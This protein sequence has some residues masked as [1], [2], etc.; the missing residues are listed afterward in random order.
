[1]TPSRP[2][3]ALTSRKATCPGA[4]WVPAVQ[5]AHGIVSHGS[6]TGGAA[7]DPGV[8][9]GLLHPTNRARQRSERAFTI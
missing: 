2:Q 7:R 6:I 1:M 8:G 5:T 9:T 4:H 3:A